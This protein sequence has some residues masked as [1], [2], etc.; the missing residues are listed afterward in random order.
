MEGAQSQSHVSWMDCF[1]PVT[2]GLLMVQP[3]AALAIH[4]R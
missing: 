2:G 4:Y 1:K 3:L